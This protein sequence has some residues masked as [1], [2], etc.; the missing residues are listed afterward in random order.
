MENIEMK[1]NEIMTKDPACC[2]GETSLIDVAKLMAEHDCGCIPVI[3]NNQDK[4]PIGTITDRDITIKTVSQSK[5][6]LNM[7]AGDIM[8]GDPVT[9]FED[10][11]VRECFQSM[12]KNR[13]RRILAVNQEGACV[14]IVAQADVA[15]KVGEHETAELVKVVSYARAA[16]A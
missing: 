12:E 4:R 13:I 2:L 15:C 6:P 8:T 9:I 11:G 7:A 16:A 1:V 14:G 3:D 10:A 5:D